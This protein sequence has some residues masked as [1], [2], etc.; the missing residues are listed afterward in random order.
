MNAMRACRA[1]ALALALA[2]VGCAG[3]ERTATDNGAKTAKS[4]NWLGN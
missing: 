4:E 1:C 2:L 3:A